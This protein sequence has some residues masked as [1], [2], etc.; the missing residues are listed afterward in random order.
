MIDGERS[1]GGNFCALDK[2]VEDANCMETSLEEIFIDCFPEALRVDDED[3]VPQMKLLALV[4]V[5]MIKT[6]RLFL[7]E[8]VGV[9]FFFVVLG[10][11]LFACVSAK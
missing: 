1:F 6:F 11:K 9:W 3:N 7:D 8:F 5:E 4:I 2:F 10:L